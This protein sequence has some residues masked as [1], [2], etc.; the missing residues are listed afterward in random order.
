MSVLD[1]ISNS[2]TI[3]T[4]AIKSSTNEIEEL[5]QYSN[6]NVP[7]EFL[8]IIREKTEIEICVNNKKYIRIWGAKGCID[9]N[10]AYNIQKYI[11][12]SLAIGDDECSNAILYTYGKKG[13]GLY[14]VAFN[15]LDTN[16][17]IYISHS[18]ESFFINGEGVDIF[19]NTW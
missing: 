14:M 13:F 9:M 11:P 4:S 1:K 3:C 15:D 10:D 16:E 2:F 18:L 6:I 17:L 19:N 8:D 5:L 7:I 12:N